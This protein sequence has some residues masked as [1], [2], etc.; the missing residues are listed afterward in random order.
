MLKGY[1]TKGGIG[2]LCLMIP[3]ISKW[4]LPSGL[5]E[6]LYVDVLGIFY[7]YIPNI[8]LLFTPLLFPRT[9]QSNKFQFAI[10]V[11][12]VLTAIVVVLFSKSTSPTY[13]IFSNFFL[14]GA[15][16]LG[17][18]HRITEKQVA[19][20]TP[21]IALGAVVIALQFILFG[22]ALVAYDFGVEGQDFG[23][24]IR[25]ASTAGAATGAGAILAVCAL[26]MIYT[27]WPAIIKWSVVL[28][29]VVG[30]FFT[31]SRSPIALLALMA[32]YLLFH[33]RKTQKKIWF[34]SIVCVVVLYSAGVFNPIIERQQQKQESDSF[35]SRRDD[36]VNETLSFVDRENAEFFGLGVG[37]VYASTEVIYAGKKVPFAG[38]PHNSYIL[39]MAE[40]GYFGLIC[41]V[42][43]MFIFILRNRRRNPELIALTLFVLATVIFSET[44]T[45]T[46]SEYVYLFAI[47]MMMI[48]SDCKYEAFSIAS[49]KTKYYPHEKSFVYSH[50]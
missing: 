49:K 40:Q 3:L 23:G 45:T 15:L 28:T 12:W 29:A 47:L 8:L 25:I 37:N 26:L 13:N 39:L 48:N 44:A 42:I 24:V 21:F 46:N 16:Y 7:L 41:V 22:T 14:A 33:Y 27:K 50:N 17:L 35:W 6:R 43:I 11:I 36:L 20:I 31:V 19:L 38:A 32:T 30:V 4:C 1:F 2:V 34:Y 5:E 10:Y 18:F 9:K